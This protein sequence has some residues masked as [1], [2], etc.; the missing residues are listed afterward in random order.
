MAAKLAAYVLAVAMLVMTNGFE[1]SVHPL[2]DS[3]EMDAAGQMPDGPP[4][5]KGQIPDAT[6]PS[7][8]PPDGEAAYEAQI[9]YDERNQQEPS[10]PGYVA[11]PAQVQAHFDDQAPADSPPSA[12]LEERERANQNM[13][14]DLKDAAQE[15]GQK[16]ES[17]KNDA[18]QAEEDMHSVEAQLKHNEGNSP[19]TKLE[20]QRTEDEEKRVDVDGQ[21]A[22]KIA[23]S[24]TLT[25]E[26]AHAV[27]SS[28]L[29]PAS[30][31]MTGTLS[32]LDKQSRVAAAALDA[33]TSIG[34][35]LQEGLARS[36]EQDITKKMEQEIASSQPVTE[37]KLERQAQQVE[38]I[39][40]ENQKAID[41]MPRISFQPVI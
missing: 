11:D 14:V 10:S 25:L 39:E 4:N 2:A 15:V 40:N 19:E 6:D 30:T 36:D 29:P 24:V 9:A 26:N 3:Y 21:A 20:L 7:M 16:L 41:G 18:H 13:L 8:R 37:Q 22:A 5:M 27:P 31:A 34:S 23:D 1:N 35:Q 17:T 32:V 33:S 28:Q 38:T 12:G